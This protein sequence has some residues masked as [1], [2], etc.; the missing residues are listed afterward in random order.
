MLVDAENPISWNRRG[1]WKGPDGEGAGRLE[2]VDSLQQSGVGEP[3]P[4]LTHR[5]SVSMR[6]P[7]VW[8]VPCYGE[9]CWCKRFGERVAY[10][11]ASPVPY[12]GQ[13]RLHELQLAA[14]PPPS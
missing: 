11:L 4:F 3:R 5:S 7:A 9:R 8:L 6:F 14:G 1:E 13:E 12:E 10:V 2:S